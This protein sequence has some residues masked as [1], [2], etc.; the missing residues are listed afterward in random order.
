MLQGE[1]A[2]L[3]PG[4]L[5]SGDTPFLGIAEQTPGAAVEYATVNKIAGYAV[6][7]ESNRVADGD[8]PSPPDASR[9][10]Y[11]LR[12]DALEC[13]PSINGDANIGFYK[14]LAAAGISADDIPVV[15][16]SVGEEELAGL[17][18]TNLVGHLAAW[19]YF[20]S[21]ES[22]ANDTWVEAWKARMGDERVTTQNLEIV[23]I[24]AERNLLLIKGAVPGAPG[25]HVAV[26][27]SVKLH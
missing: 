4:G 2:Y 17:D 25:G 10:Y 12:S 14:E 15:A 27:P 3:G 7:V 9:L 21:A 6:G 18:T 26:R 11:T 19:N 1:T 23:R 20:Q 24:D 5:N 16:F 8:V 13:S 22:D